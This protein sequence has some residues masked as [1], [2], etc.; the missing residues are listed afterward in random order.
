M[1]ILGQDLV[2]VRLRKSLELISKEGAGLSKK[3]LKKLEK[4]YRTKYSEKIN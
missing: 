1:E 4:E 3:G 2:R